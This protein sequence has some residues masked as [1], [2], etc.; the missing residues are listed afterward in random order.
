HFGRGLRDFTASR[1]FYEPLA[2][3]TPEGTFVPVLADELPSVASGTLARDA[4]W[5]IWRLKRNVVWHDGAPFTADDVVFNWEF[6]A[7]PATGATSRAV[8]D[9][10][11]RVDRLDSHTVKVVFRKPRPFWARAFTTDGLLPRHVF[12]RHRGSGA[13]EALGAARVV[14][15]GPY[16]LVEFTPGDLLRAELNPHYHVDRRPHF[17]R[18]EIKG[19]GDAVSAARAVMQ[20]GE[21]D[22]AYYVMAEEDVLRRVEQGGKG[23]IL[24]VPGSGVSHIQCNQSD[25][26]R[27]VDGERPSARAPHPC[28]TAPEVRAALALLVDRAAIQEHLVGR[29]GQPTANFLN[30]PARFRS[31]NTRWEFNVDKANRLLDDA[32]WVRGPDGV[33][34][35]NGQRLR[36]V[37]QAAVSASVQ[38]VQMIVKQAAAKA[39]IAIEVKAVPAGTFFSSDTSTADSNVRFLADLQMYTVFTGLDPQLFMAQFCSWEI[40]T[41]D[42]RWTGRNLT[43][44]QSPEYDRLWRQAESEMD[45][46]KRAALFVRMNDLVVQEHVVI[47]V[48]WRNLLHA[49][50]HRLAGIELNGWDSVFGRIAY[51]HRTA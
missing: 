7:D 50:S 29:N 35:R 8:Y 4:Q 32:G 5:V 51:W 45:P 1:I 30:A 31:P 28:L 15:T 10:I 36:F 19:G 38:K 37:F 42:N 17:D 6:A 12:E 43:R 49:A 24:V 22:F 41:R 40:P 20:T 11:A 2:A 34:A 14:G 21:Y 25:P 26:W 13:R 27:E 46:V 9:E 48:T 39:G 47:P 16:R 33:R 44:W 3:P 18:L 23:R